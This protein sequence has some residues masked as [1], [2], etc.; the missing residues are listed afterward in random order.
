[1]PPLRPLVLLVLSLPALAATSFETEVL[2]LLRARCL[3]CHAGNPQGKLD[4][5]MPESMLKGG[6][7]GPAIVP[8]QSAKSLLIDKL[9]TRTMPPGKDKLSDAE[10]STLRR[11]IDAYTPPQIV[12]EHDVLPIFQVRCVTCHGKREQRGGLDLRTVASRLKGGKSGPAII[13][14]DPDNS[15]IIRRIVSGEMPPAKEQLERSVR[16]PTENEVARLKA[17]IA[18][19]APAGPPRNTA[20]AGDDDPLVPDKDRRFWAF[21]PPRRPEVPKVKNPR[22]V[23]NPID[24]FLLEKLEAK[25]LRFSAEA[26]PAK[27]ARRAYLDLTGMPPS[28]AEMSAFLAD[29]RPDAYERLVD[30]LLASPRYG[31]RWAR[32]WLDLAGYSDSEGFGQDD[33]VRR[34]AWRY[35]DYVIRSLNEDKPYSQFLTEQIAGDEMI[36]G[37]PPAAASRPAPVDAKTLDRLAATGYLRNTP[38]PTNAPERGFIA[39]RM[40]IIADEMEV[41][42]SSV[43][44]L[45]VGCARCHNH[46]Y[47]PIPQ[48]DYYRLAAILETAYD[49]YDWLPPKNREYPVAASEEIQDW[50]QHNA[51]ID[52]EIGGLEKTLAELKKSDDDKKRAES[53]QAEINR[54]KG[55]LKP[56]PHVRVLMDTGGEPSAFYLL[57]RGDPLTPGE[58]VTPGVPSVLKA[59]LEPYRV[60]PPWPG[61]ASSGRRLALA[62]WLTQPNHPL[63]ARVAVNH[64]WLRHFGR[65]LVASPSN[66]GRSGAPPSHPELLDWL[67]TEF[68]RQGWSLKAIHRLMLTSSAYRQASTLEAPPAAD[69]DNVLLSRMPLRRMDAES[70]YDSVLRVTGRLDAKMFGAPAEIEIK[71]DKEVVVKGEKAGFRRAIYVLHRR[72]T[73]VTMFEVFDQPPMTPNCVERRQSNVA[74]QALQMMNGTLLWDHARYLAGRLVDE[75]GD[76]AAQAYQRI[77]SRNPSPDEARDAQASLSEFTRIWE[78]KLKSDNTEAPVALTARWQALATLCHTL[79]NSAEFAYVD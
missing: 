47:D 4:L 79:L 36:S 17:W 68:V 18:A 10:I 53:V 16:P 65:G 5:R 22:L 24:A 63:T 26:P 15:L 27:L 8:G 72:Q 60:E 29:T 78:E 33:G 77:L 71:P 61:S 40:N 75:G 38:D 70:L 54:L 9:V 39:E 2:P 14:G 25:G 46:K 43:M 19:G 28:P 51:P 45:T 11:W 73:P 3:A 50:D 58:Y 20:A 1:M 69:P 64:L 57:R 67:A 7:S 41:L 66:F 13:P 32:H 35:R 6:I 31:E 49:P 74:T 21:Q 52:A 34:F 42:T 59:G 12:T 62:R 56:K 23:R 30:A 44:G 76:V 55:K 48:R 37:L